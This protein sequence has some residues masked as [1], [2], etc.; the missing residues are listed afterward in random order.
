MLMHVSKLSR[1]THIVISDVS[2][3]IYTMTE[4]Y[5]MD[6]SRK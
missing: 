2:Y 5:M 3:I 6:V 1:Y 4:L